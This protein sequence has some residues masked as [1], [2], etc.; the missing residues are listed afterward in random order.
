M[1][2]PDPLGYLL[3]TVLF[4]LHIMPLTTISWVSFYDEVTGDCSFVLY[5]IVPHANFITY[6]SHVAT[7]SWM[8]PHW[9]PHG[10]I[11]QVVCVLALC[12]RFLLPYQFCHFC[13]LG[14]PCLHQF[15]PLMPIHLVLSSFKN[16]FALPMLRPS[17]GSCKMLWMISSWPRGDLQC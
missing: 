16:L 5:K 8:L 9:N 12:W 14:H 10:C 2:C 13:C 15:V 6:L 17:H 7:F 4:F 11:T 1:G 3:H